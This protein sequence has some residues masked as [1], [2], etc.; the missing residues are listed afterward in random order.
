MHAQTISPES[1][2]RTEG[3][4]IRRASFYD[5]LVNILTLGQSSRM[6]RMTIDLA[7][8]NPGESLLDVGCGT[9]GVAI[10]AK[11]RVG[12]AGKIAG[13]DPSPEMLAVARRNALR[14]GLEIDFR[15]GA[16]EAL[17]YDDATFDAVTASLMIHHLRGDLVERGAAE[18]LR[19]LKP[20]G[21]LL[22]VDTMRSARFPAKQF[23]ALLERRHGIRFG[24]EE[25]PPILRSVGFSAV[26]LL[27]DRF[28]M[29]GFLRATKPWG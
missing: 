2:Y 11:M 8:L 18:I 5:T 9:G 13:I 16:I 1:A 3:L 22:V 19:V 25:L 15:L 17:P 10:P 21:R 20:G 12:S 6:R 29:I 26:R 7:L 23:L 28:R 4:L 24:I 27:D 14:R